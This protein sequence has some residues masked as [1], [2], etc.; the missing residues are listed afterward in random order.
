MIAM[1]NNTERNPFDGW[2]GDEGE[3]GMTTLTQSG[4]LSNDKSIVTRLIKFNIID[5]L[6]SN[7]QSESTSQRAKKLIVWAIS[8]ICNESD[9]I[10]FLFEKKVFSLLLIIIHRNSLNELKQILTSYKD[11]D[12]LLKTLVCFV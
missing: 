12:I 11:P 1:N 4:Q 9:M 3:Q 2:I 7:L 6:L 10:D 5:L 8:N